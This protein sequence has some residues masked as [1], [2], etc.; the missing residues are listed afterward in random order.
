LGSI[1]AN[2]RIPKKGKEFLCYACKNIFLLEEKQVISRHNYCKKCATKKFL[3]EEK[4]KK[5][6]INDVPFGTEQFKKNDEIYI[7]D[8]HIINYE[9]VR[10]IVDYILDLYDLD[11]KAHYAYLTMQVNHLINNYHCSYQGIYLTLKYYFKL[12]ENPIPSEPHIITIVATNYDKAIAAWKLQDKLTK[13]ADELI[14]EKVPIVN[15]YVARSAQKQY[16]S[17]YDNNRWRAYENMISIDDI[18]I[19]EENDGV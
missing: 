7:G 17:Y 19:T 12:L 1:S 2:E 15:I 16:N 18:E 8:E 14:S 11:P 6:N 10:E 13:K 5:T 4:A 3:A 9:N